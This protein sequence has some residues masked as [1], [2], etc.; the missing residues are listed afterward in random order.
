M[1]LVS[2]V[3]HVFA[4]VE[5]NLIDPIVNSYRPFQRGIRITKGPSSNSN[6]IS[7]KIKI[8]WRTPLFDS[9]IVSTF[10]L[11]EASKNLVHIVKKEFVSRKIQ[12]T[13]C[14]H[15]KESFQETLWN[16][17]LQLLST[18][19]P[20]LPVLTRLNFVNHSITIRS[21]NFSPLR[22]SP[23]LADFIIPY[24]TLCST[25]IVTWR[26]LFQKWSSKNQ[27]SME[28]F[29]STKKLQAALSRLIH[30]ENCPCHHR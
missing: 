5:I 25:R 7:R 28:W 27:A 6:S 20:P 23:K 16:C 1:C 2:F 30:F 9:R 21:R 17:P 18:F 10:I 14:S 26:I 24:F 29:G 4:S 3:I 8:R 13:I 22:T 15:F 19:L 12:T 11:H